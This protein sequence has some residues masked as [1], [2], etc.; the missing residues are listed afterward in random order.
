MF[1][2]VS[3]LYVDKKQLRTAWCISSSIMHHFS[4]NWQPGVNSK[5]D[6]TVDEFIKGSTFLGI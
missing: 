1:W 6:I 2:A 4:K 3:G 5:N